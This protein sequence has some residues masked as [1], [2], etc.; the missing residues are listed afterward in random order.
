MRDGDDSIQ[1]YYQKKMRF[2][3]KLWYEA[4]LSELKIWW[5]LP[6]L[7]DTKTHNVKSGKRMDTNGE[8]P[9]NFHKSSSFCRWYVRV[10]FCLLWGLGREWWG[11]CTQFE[12]LTHHSP[13]LKTPTTH[14]C[15]AKTKKARKNNNKNG[16]FNV[17]KPNSGKIECKERSIPL[18]QTLFSLKKHLS[19]LGGRELLG[20]WTSA[21]FFFF[22][23]FFSPS[24]PVYMQR[25]RD[26]CLCKADFLCCVVIV[27]VSVS[28]VM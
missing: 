27:I 28:Y 3:N 22:S 9:F 23:L 19:W 24:N 15:T 5:L 20:F 2:L 4:L 21:F 1:L 7:V 17:K 10:G 14:Y 26:C 13:L 18:S 12:G 16:I 11:F 25:L 6:K 8:V